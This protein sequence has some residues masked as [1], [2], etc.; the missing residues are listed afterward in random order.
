[1]AKGVALWTFSVVAVPLGQL[2]RGMAYRAGPRGTMEKAIGDFVLFGVLLLEIPVHGFKLP[3]RRWTMVFER[4]TWAPSE[5]ISKACR[6]S[7]G[8]LKL[9]SWVPWG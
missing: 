4:V 3:Y 1:M 7:L 9:I 6:I 2:K 5:M 8:I